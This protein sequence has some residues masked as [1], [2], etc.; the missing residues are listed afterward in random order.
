[1]EGFHSPIKN[2]FQTGL[3]RGQKRLP[4]DP[5]KQYAYMKHPVEGWSVYMRSCAFLFVEGTG[6]V[7][8]DPSKF[9]VVK[10]M[11]SSPNGKT[12]EPPKGQMEGKDADIYSRRPRS[13]LKILKENV[14]REIYEEAHI[15]KI[16]GL[17]HTGLVFQDREYNYPPGTFFQY[18][19]FYGT[20]SDAEYNAAQEYFKSLQEHPEILETLTR[21]CLEKDAIAIYEHGKTKLFGRWS[22]KIVKLWLGVFSHPSL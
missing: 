17:H 20:I 1:M 5:E 3:I 14:R 6:T 12:W 10:K 21:D 9:I 8:T 13:A 4:H 7:L 16:K 15:K 11:G 18:H 19:I 22:P 2:I